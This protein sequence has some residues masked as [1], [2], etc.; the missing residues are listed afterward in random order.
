MSCYPI[1]RLNKL[2]ENFP[3]ELRYILDERIQELLDT[4]P[5]LQVTF[6]GERFSL[7]KEEKKQDQ[8]LLTIRDELAEFLNIPVGVYNADVITQGIYKYLNDNNLEIDLNL[9]KSDEK[10]CKLFEIDG[11]QPLNYSSFR[12]LPSKHYILEKD[13]AFVDI[14][15]HVENRHF[16]PK[17]IALGVADVITNEPKYTVVPN[18]ICKF[19]SLVNHVTYVSPYAHLEPDYTKNIAKQFDIEEE[20]GIVENELHKKIMNKLN[21]N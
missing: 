7:N 10:L 6:D 3:R 2:Y 19:A 17:H 21:T 20:K 9:Y 8:T 12:C 14:I 16:E 13:P 18:N 11:T 4:L 5:K 1:D 15:G